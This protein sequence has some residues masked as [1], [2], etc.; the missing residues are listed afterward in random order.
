M[1]SRNPIRG[2]EQELVV[3]RE[4]FDVVDERARIAEVSQRVRKRDARRVF[5]WSVA[6]DGTLAAVGSWEGIPASVAGLAA[7]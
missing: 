6:D 5:G 3:V 1:R 2:A 7:R 4:L